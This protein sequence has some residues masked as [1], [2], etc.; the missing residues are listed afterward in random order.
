MLL[1]VLHC[2]GPKILN[3]NMY[4]SIF[5]ALLHVGHSTVL[6]CTEVTVIAPEWTASM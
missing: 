4:S 2:E 1:N 3:I 6:T 5:Q